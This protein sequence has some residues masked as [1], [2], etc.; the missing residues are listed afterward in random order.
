[1][2]PSLSEITATGR[3]AAKGAGYS[4]GQADEV[5][6][7]TAWL[8][9]HGIDSITPLAELLDYGTPKTCPIRIG[10]RLCDA[11]PHSMQSAETVQSPILLLFFTGELG[12]IT[13]STVKLT[14]GEAIYFTTPE[15]MFIAQSGAVG[16]V[17]V[18]CNAGAPNGKQL[19]PQP[20][21]TVPKGAWSRLEHWEHKTYAP[22]SEKSRL[23]GAGAG[24]SDND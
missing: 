22:A 15:A 6:R 23:A 14:I 1:M 11:P 5:G 4:W 16:A 7:A 17:T 24:L 2:T 12:K 20:R 10:T 21:R 13:N 9:E 19:P 8:W 18:T 3:K